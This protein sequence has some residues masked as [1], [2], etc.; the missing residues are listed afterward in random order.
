MSTRKPAL[1]QRGILCRGADGHIWFRQYDSNY[2]FVDYD[3]AHYDCAIEI[4]DD[5][6]VLIRNE[7]GDFLDYSEEAQSA[8]TSEHDHD[9]CHI[10]PEVDSPA[11]V[12]LDLP[13]HHLFK[14]MMLAHE[15]NITLNQLIEQTLA[16][17]VGQPPT[18]DY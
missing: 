1:G 10:D 5:S 9:Q 6:A 7:R 2:D 17:V 18:K 12:E 3:I 11:E 4:T 15:K 8:C 16:R 13:D 14:L